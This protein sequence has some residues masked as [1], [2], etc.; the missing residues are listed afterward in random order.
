MWR[1]IGNPNPIEKAKWICA[2]AL[3]ISAE[4]LAQEK[5]QVPQQNKRMVLIS[6]PDRK[7]ALIEN[8]EVK[9]VYTVAV[10]KA[11]TP[12]P[13]G[14]FRVANRLKN[15]A[16]YHAG[17]VIGPGAQ[18][19]L[20]EFWIGLDL[21]GYGIHGT[22]AP[23]SIG[24]A[25]SHGCIRMAKT[26]LAELFA[27][28]RHGDEVQI[29]AELDTETARLFNPAPVILAQVETQAVHGN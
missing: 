9:R 1:M 24:K 3:L 14:T 5:Q 12:S 2:M 18:N 17:T 26:D 15:P 16:Y 13:V 21:K 11:S 6:I 23:K 25:A 10:G 29:R 22:N 4:A 20:G 19:P 27:V 28:L 7:L 8:G